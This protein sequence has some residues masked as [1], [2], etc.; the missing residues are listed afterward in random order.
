[1]LLGSGG[2]RLH[3]TRQDKARQE[4]SRF[5]AIMSAPRVTN[6]KSVAAERGK[7]EGA[8]PCLLLPCTVSCPSALQC[9]LFAMV[10]GGRCRDDRTYC[11]YSV[12]GGTLL[13][14]DGPGEYKPVSAL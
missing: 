4:N 3:K 12:F 6:H 8:F 14:R 9:R 11:R 5:R 13:G 7:D 2:E 1:M 10:V